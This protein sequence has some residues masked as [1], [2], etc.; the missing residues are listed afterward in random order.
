MVVG[1]IPLTSGGPTNYREVV[2]HPQGD[3]LYVDARSQ[4]VLPF[5]IDTAAALFNDRLVALNPLSI[6]SIQYLDINS[7]SGD[8]LLT[9][10][11]FTP[12]L[13]SASQDD[14]LVE[15]Q[16]SI[17]N[18]GVCVS[19]RFGA[20]EVHVDSTSGVTVFQARWMNTVRRAPGMNGDEHF[21]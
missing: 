6:P 3:V 1:D 18:P 10:P 19:D 4:T 7:I 9:Y 21:R 13:A 17:Q 5:R 20:N 12:Q 2:L 16:S 14:V 11:D 8:L 15:P